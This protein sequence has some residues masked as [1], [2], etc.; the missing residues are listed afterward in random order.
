MASGRQDDAAGIVLNKHGH[1]SGRFNQ[2][3]LQQWN[4]T[5]LRLTPP[6]FGAKRSNAASGERVW[7]LHRP[8]EQPDAILAKLLTDLAECGIVVSYYAII[9][10]SH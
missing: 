10:R 3:V 2:S 1:W 8:S 9:G 6:N 4:C 5:Q 7:L